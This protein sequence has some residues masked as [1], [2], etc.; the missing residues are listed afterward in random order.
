MHD[1]KVSEAAAK[2]G[3]SEAKLREMIKLGLVDAY[4]LTPRTTRIRVEEFNR[5][6]GC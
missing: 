5:L 2:L 4:K 6:R 1:L 3:V